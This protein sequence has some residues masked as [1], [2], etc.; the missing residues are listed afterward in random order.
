MKLA[1]FTSA[2][3]TGS[4][5]L[6]Q[7]TMSAIKSGYLNAEIV[8]VVCNREQGQSAFTDA[9]FN[10]VQRHNIP[11]ITQSSLHW[12]KR[13]RG[14]ITQNPRAR[15]ASWRNEYDAE[16][17]KKI[18]PYTPDIALLA[19]YMLVLTES[20]VN[21]LPV[22]NLHPALPKGPTGTYQEVIHSLI[23]ADATKSGIQM[24]RVTPE[25]D[26]GEVVSWCEYAIPNSPK[27]KNAQ[28]IL[29]SLLFNAIRA[30]GVERES[31]FMIE[32][33]VAL[34]QKTNATH[35]ID[36]TQVVESRLVDRPY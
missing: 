17:L 19:G 30:K 31:I 34:S 3:G 4:R 20:L 23:L 1:Y 22:F 2:R 13:V 10:E 29:T 8:C 9:F 28:T 6:F 36:L 27:P 35:P 32:S 21:A 5:N 7:T 12:R 11:L 15:I 33:L 16:I 14:E 18:A 24:Q 26:K 25:L